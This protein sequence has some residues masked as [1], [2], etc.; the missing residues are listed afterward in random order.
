MRL[1]WTT[2]TI[3]RRT[4]ETSTTISR[5]HTVMATGVTVTSTALAV[6]IQLPTFKV[7][8]LKIVL[9]GEEVLGGFDHHVIGQVD[10]ITHDYLPY[11][12]ARCHTPMA[13]VRRKGEGSDG[14]P[15]PR[16]MVTRPEPLLAQFPAC[17]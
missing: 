12:G 11:R 6:I 9:R 14:R 15:S 1:S 17:D 2:R 3:I 16:W 13:G 8:L 7:V 4:T 5:R 10:L